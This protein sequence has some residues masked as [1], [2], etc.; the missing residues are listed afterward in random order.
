MA[1]KHSGNGAAVAAATAAG[2]A[3]G[4]LAPPLI[5]RLQGAITS[6]LAGGDDTTQAV[7]AGLSSSKSVRISVSK[8]EAFLTDVLVSAGCSTRHAQRVASVL[9]F[10][11]ARGIPSHGVNRLDTYL[12]EIEAGLVDGTA[13]PIV[14]R[15]SGS[16][17]VIDGRNG[18]GAVTSELAMKTAIDLAKEHGVSVV[19]CHSSNHFGAAG[20]WAKMALDE[21][22]IAMSFT[23]TSPFAVPTG[24]RGV[25]AVGTN[26]FC[27]FAPAANRE[28]FQLDMA[29]TV[30]PVGK[31][32]VMHRI[33]KPVPSGWGVDRDGENCTD[34][35]EI[36]KVG[37]LYPLG[38]REETAGYKGYGLGMFV[39]ILSSV[40]SGAAIGPDVQ[41]W[42]VTRDGGI[43][44]G[45]CFIVIDPKRYVP[46]FELRLGD[47]LEKMRSLKGQVMVAG[48]PEKKFE[49]DA[50]ENGVLL[51]ESVATTMKSLAS[52]F[53]VEPPPEFKSLDASKSK[54]SL[55]SS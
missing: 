53:G 11:D 17:A 29:T 41:S 18:L 35:E 38:G 23:N 54:D 25:R 9:T 20:Y 26:P 8:L 36:C 44:Y 28:S 51:H 14:S 19:V 1:P 42:S 15:I 22:F 55:Y 3:I 47:Y 21:G 45:H 43:N 24:A 46:G 32:E 10:A 6:R 2:I 33:N 37:G 4:I 7:R 13:D 50:A 31:I 30:V 52:R 27:M 39:E 5:R 40:L 49:K 12:N 48:D 16:C 34:P